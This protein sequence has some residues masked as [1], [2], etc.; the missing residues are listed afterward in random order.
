MGA[1]RTLRATAEGGAMGWPGGQFPICPPIIPNRG[2]TTSAGWRRY[3]DLG[4]F[5]LANKP[6]WI[7]IITPDEPIKEFNRKGDSMI[8]TST[9]NSPKPPHR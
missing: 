2:E 4:K 9:K 7:M 6:P 1:T 8:I 3:V 5:L